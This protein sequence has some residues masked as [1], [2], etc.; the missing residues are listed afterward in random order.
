MS[1]RGPWEL[2]GVGCAWLWAG[3]RKALSAVEGWELDGESDV[4]QNHASLMVKGRVQDIAGRSTTW[5]CSSSLRISESSAPS[6]VPGS[7]MCLAK[8]LC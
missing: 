4:V 2:A 8:D 7:K 3:D 6:S 5:Y 1:G